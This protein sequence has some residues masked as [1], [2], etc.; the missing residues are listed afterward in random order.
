MS[1]DRTIPLASKPVIHFVDTPKSKGALVHYQTINMSEEDIL[2]RYQILFSS[3][4]NNVSY[5]QDE[6]R[7]YCKYF[8]TWLLASFS[9]CC[10]SNI[11]VWYGV[12]RVGR[13]ASVFGSFSGRSERTAAAFVFIF[14]LWSLVS[15][16]A[17][18]WQVWWW[19]KTALKVS[20]RNT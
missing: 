12:G 8:N 5:H 14:P 4:P 1:T 19:R 11:H 16:G 20:K 2:V 10:A 9:L 18:T 7:R 17:A 15:S 13:A 6:G 3:Y